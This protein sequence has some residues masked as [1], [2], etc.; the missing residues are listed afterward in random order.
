MRNLLL[1]ILL[2][3]LAGLPAAA[4]HA[5]FLGVELN[6]SQLEFK[7]Q[8]LRVSGVTCLE[9]R[10]DDAAF[11]YSGP[12]AGVDS[13]EFYV[14]T[15]N[16]S[17]CAVSVLLPKADSWA[18][19]KAQFTQIR[20]DLRFD[21]TLRRTVDNHSF[22][23]PY[24]EG[25]GDEMLAVANNMCSFR[26]G[27]KNDLGTI[28]VSINKRKCVKID[29][30]DNQNYSR[31]QEQLPGTNANPSVSQ[32][33]DPA[34]E[35]LQFMGLNITG[36]P[37]EFAT[38][39]V[40][41]RGL[42]FHSRSSNGNYILTGTY[43]GID[44][45][46]FGILTKE[47]RISSIGVTLPRLDSWDAIRSRYISFKTALRN[48]YELIRCTESF[49]APYSEGDGDEM[50]AVLAGKCTFRVV[51]ASA[52]GDIVLSISKKGELIILFMPKK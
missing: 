26:A 20:D 23:P 7:Q 2:F 36:K 45:C 32:A 5:R 10:C 9:Q 8:L 44:N 24:A 12:Y 42:T 6:G 41:E 17:V 35:Y 30:F 28:T 11:V 13:C 37:S 14:F 43:Q 51:F 40:N 34:G 33:N 52:T 1:C 25:D 3:T 38:R 4:E 19:L 21:A 31:P 29:F 15:Q 39:L 27:F 22:T 48:E 16:G 18:Q 47:G 50:Q 49:A 46:S